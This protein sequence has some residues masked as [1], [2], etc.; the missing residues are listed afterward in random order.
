MFEVWLKLR[1]KVDATDAK[2]A[3]RAARLHL[4]TCL[5]LGGFGEEEKAATLDV[6]RPLLEGFRGL[7]R[8]E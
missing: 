8:R 4:K 7:G 1:F 5:E 6:V 2:E 3:E